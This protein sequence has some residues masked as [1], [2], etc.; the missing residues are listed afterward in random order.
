MEGFSRVNADEFAFHPDGYEAMPAIMGTVL[1][2]GRAC[3]FS[4]PNGRNNAFADICLGRRDPSIK[5]IKVHWR[6]IPGRDDAWKARVMREMMWTDSDWARE[7][8]F[9][10]DVV[11][12]PKMFEEFDYLTHVKTL[13]PRFPDV[14][15][16]LCGWDIGFECPAA[17]L[18]FVNSHDQLII[19]TAIAGHRPKG[20]F[21]AFIREVQEYRHSLFARNHWID[22]TP[23]DTTTA[24]TESGTTYKEMFEEKGIYPE[25]QKTKKPEIGWDLIRKMLAVRADGLPG[26]VVNDEGTYFTKTSENKVPELRNV[27]M[28]GFQGSF[29]RKQQKLPEGVRY[30][31]EPNRQHPYID[32]FDA[33]NCLVMGF[34]RNRSD[35]DSW[36]HEDSSEIHQPM[37]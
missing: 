36:D 31:D 6:E 27:V 35:I 5:P 37:I 18:C 28:E 1:D 14:N 34:Y 13:E 12:G 16:G 32:V 19:H 20:G 3:I 8:E 23:H 10:F 29:T 17:V 25:I 2:G 33:L 21:P 9:S 11:L 24:S 26:I 15:F 30:S 7:M 4:T 22:W